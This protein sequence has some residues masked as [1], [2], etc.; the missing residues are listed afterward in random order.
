[1]ADPVLQ[2]QGLSKQLGGRTVVDAVSIAVGGGE[3][4]GV[5]GPNGAGKTTLLRMLV[6]WIRPDSGRVLLGGTDLTA[7]PVHARARLGLGY[8]PQTPS[9]FSGLSVEDNLRAVLELRGLPPARSGELLGMFGLQAL[10]RQRA[11][12]LSGGERRRLELARLL[13]VEPRVVLLDEPLKGLDTGVVERV[14][15]MLRERARTGG[16]V[17]LADHAVGHM[18]ELCH[19]VYIVEDGRL[20]A[21]GEP[22]QVLGDRGFGVERLTRAM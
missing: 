22:G 4:V 8:L 10:A 16:S 11:A 20:V 19:R 18:I 9:V 2:G 15:E 17:L 5:L 12:L 7:L 3:I 6:G 13:A 1:M 21:E 14:K